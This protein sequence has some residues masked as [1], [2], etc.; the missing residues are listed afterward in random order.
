M[1]DW[2]QLDKLFCQPMDL[3]VSVWHSRSLTIPPAWF[4]QLPITNFQLWGMLSTTG[5]VTKDWS[6]GGIKYLM[7]FL[8]PDS[9][10][11]SASSQG[12]RLSLT[13]LLLL[14]YLQ[15]VIFSAQWFWHV[16]G[17]PLPYIP[18]L[19]GFPYKASCSLSVVSAAEG[20]CRA[21]VFPGIPKTSSCSPKTPLTRGRW[22]DQGV[23]W[24]CAS[25]QGCASMR[26]RVCL[27]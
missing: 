19:Q 9:M 4:T 27:R 23:C 11:P 10:L 3:W 13:L 15:K 18:S 14:I 2:K 8:I 16:H 21:A 7:L 20:Q 22:G 1:N 5:F 26:T 24:G 6:Q 12:W 17:F 25:L